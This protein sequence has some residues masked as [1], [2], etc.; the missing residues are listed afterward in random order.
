MAP[1]SNGVTSPC[2][3]LPNS[4]DWTAPS[5]LDPVRSS[6]KTCRIFASAASTQLEIGDRE[7]GELC[8]TESEKA[9]S[10]VAHLLPAMTFGEERQRFET[11]LG[12]LRKI[13][14]QLPRL[15]N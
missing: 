4:Q 7:A 3:N 10:V 2:D 6:L 1:D 5:R 13:L 14:D 15:G 9:F 8:A 12:K 11:E